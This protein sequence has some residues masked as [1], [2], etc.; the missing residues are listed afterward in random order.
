MDSVLSGSRIPMATQPE[1]K[2]RSAASTQQLAT[3]L[4]LPGGGARAAYQVGVLKAI[5]R[6]LPRGR[7][8]PFPILTGTSA[9]AINA[10]TLACHADRFRAGVR[11][12]ESVWRGFRTNQVFRTDA[13]A[14]IRSSLHWVATLLLG[15]LGSHNPRSLFDNAPL[16]ALLDERIPTARIQ[17][18]IDAGTLQTVAV[19]LSSYR[20]GRSVSFYQGQPS[21]RAWKRARREG[22]P[23]SI[24]IDH[25]MASAAVPMIFPAEKVG[26]EFFGDGAMR[27]MM[28]L[29]PAIRLGADRLLVIGVRNE[30]PW[31]AASD[32]SP[33]GRPTL[34]QIAGYMLDTLF[35]DG[36]Y[37]DLERV[38]RI[39]L[40]LDHIGAETP[41]GAIRRVETLVILPSRDLREMALEYADEMPLSVRLLLRG[42]GAY[43][44]G[45]GQLLSYLLFERGYT[46][47]L[48]R[49][50]YEDA[51]EQADGIASFLRGEPAPAIDAP[52]SVAADLSGQF[53]RPDF[54][55][56]DLAE[57][58]DLAD[59]YQSPG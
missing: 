50:G 56:S 48:I 45:G 58:G 24:R 22:R 44:K 31:N 43:G 47:A 51:M 9:G 6:L 39:N 20:S 12:L 19:T 57:T 38:T 59:A 42:L 27:Q 8:C 35:M 53:R 36:L 1:E 55:E 3:G 16:R 13:P 40:L 18:Q 49:L 17:G 7:S 25:L 14:M 33:G 15:G 34:G 46:Q 5:G 54:T 4:V 52:N 32:A 21:Q 26:D 29:S 11:V 37:S 10:V 28:P 41:D 23:A 30:R 2:T